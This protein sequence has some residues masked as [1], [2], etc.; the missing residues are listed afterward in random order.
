MNIYSPPADEPT[1]LMVGDREP[2]AA[3]IREAMQRY[4]LAVETASVIDATQSAVASAPDLVLLV[5]DATIDGGSDLLGRLHASPMLSVLPVVL[6]ADD[7]RLDDRLRAFRFGAAAVVARSASVDSIA[8][9]IAKLAREIPERT[10][11]RTGELGE[12]T[13]DDFAEMLKK[14]LRNG[15]VSVKTRG[16]DEQAT[17][18]MVFGE[19]RTI[20]ELVEGFVSRVRP[21]VRSTEVL[22]YEFEEHAGGTL[23]LLDAELSGPA[24]PAGSIEGMRILLA[25]NEPARADALAQELR[26]RGASVVVSDLEGRGLDRATAMD[27]AVLIIDQTALESE[28]YELVRGMR[29]DLRLRWASLLAIN[30]GE[31]TSNRLQSTTIES[32]VARLSQL[33]ELE[34][35]ISDQTARAEHFDTRIESLGPAR[36]LRALAKSHHASVRH[37]QAS[38][39]DAHALRIVVHNRRAVAQIDI[40]GELV[41]GASC[42]LRESGKILEGMSAVAALLQIASG[43]V[44]IEH[45]LSPAAANVMS[46]LDVTL[47]NASGEEPPIR[48]SMPAAPLPEEAQE[49]AQLLT[50]SLHPSMRPMGQQS[51]ERLSQMPG[52]VSSPDRDFTANDDSAEITVS[53]AIPMDAADASLL[54][55]LPRHT[56]PLG[57]GTANPQSSVSSR[58]PQKKRRDRTLI[59]IPVQRR[60]TLRPSSSKESVDSGPEKEMAESDPPIPI[61]IQELPPRVAP[62]PAAAVLKPAAP[63]PVVREARGPSPSKAVSAQRVPGESQELAGKQPRWPGA[64]SSRSWPRSAELLSDEPLSDEPT[65]PGA[66]ALLSDEPTAVNTMLPGESTVPRAEAIARHVPDAITQEPDAYP[67]GVF[68]KIGDLDE[69]PTRVDSSGEPESEAAPEQLSPLD[70]ERT[71][72]PRVESVAFQQ[73][74]LRKLLGMAAALLLLS[75]V[76]AAISIAVLDEDVSQNAFETTPLAPHP[77]AEE[78]ATPIALVDEHARV[79]EHGSTAAQTDRADEHAGAVQKEEAGEHPAAQAANAVDTNVNDDPSSDIDGNSSVEVTE[80]DPAE[81]PDEENAP[82]EVDQESAPESPEE[83]GSSGELAQQP[84]ESSDPSDPADVSSDSIAAGSTNAID[85]SGA[86]GPTATAAIELPERSRKARRL[87]SRA[88][89]I[90]IARYLGSANRSLRTGHWRRAEDYFREVMGLDPSNSEAARGLALALYRRGY[91]E[92][93]YTWLRHALSLSPEDPEA[94]LLL[95]DALGVRDLYDEALTAWNRVLELEPGHRQASRRIQVM[96]RRMRRLEEAEE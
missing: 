23:Q 40:Q 93:A 95:G 75:A 68:P 69:E 89:A 5:G 4:G 88:L 30:W 44:R 83:E 59:G 35:M 66:E 46:T 50:A 6:L 55:N 31:V 17:I 71:Y 51:M 63:P 45:V 7:E 61:D 12:A 18:R 64:P 24:G 96:R 11:T 74:R 25:D 20:A 58:P 72:I 57:I 73:E 21:L 9:K 3:G 2:L 13:L 53:K 28:G 79:D 94:Y 67:G 10:G 92:R 81:E 14:E 29:H 70:F 90:E 1:V 56:S 42:E 15:I 84:A 32:M 34:Q 80:N 62:P 43:R 47:A 19:G 87:S 22:R 39:I 27:P 16:A 38:A 86:P 77:A 26:A 54:S 33:N 41:A 65:V 91:E 49:A 78:R 82:S 8:R 52:S 60:T 48:P 76:I 85:N 37:P 36:L